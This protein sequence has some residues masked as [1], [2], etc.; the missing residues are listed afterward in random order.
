MAVKTKLSDAELADAAVR[1]RSGETWKAVASYYGVDRC[2]LCR[3]FRLAGVDYKRRFYKCQGRKL[4]IPAEPTELAYIAGLFDGEGHL[5][6]QSDRYS[7]E[8]A[9]T[10]RE[11][12]DW[13]LR[14]GGKVRKSSR[15]PHQ[16]CYH[17]RVHAQ[18]DVH[19]L[20]EALRPYLIIKRRISEQAI[21]AIG[22]R[23]YRQG[24][25]HSG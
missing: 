25:N 13:L 10:N 1:I 5:G 15:E 14:L 23:P 19:A 18:L 9:N 8:I 4:T 20:L 24:S 21:T 22:H 6:F 11:V 17:W 7:V 12:M 16:D 3:H 2:D